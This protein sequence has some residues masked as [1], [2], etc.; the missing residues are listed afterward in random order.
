MFGC[1][2]NDGPG[3]WPGP[4]REIEYRNT[5]VNRKTLREWHRSRLSRS[6]QIK[7]FLEYTAFL[8]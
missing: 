3:D 2:L 4:V 1:K 6:F 7:V 5:S 8:K